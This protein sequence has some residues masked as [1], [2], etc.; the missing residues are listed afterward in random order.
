MAD[1]GNTPSKYDDVNVRA[2]V[3]AVIADPKIDHLGDAGDLRHLAGTGDHT[4]WSTHTGKYGYPTQGK[5]HAHD[6]SMSQADQNLFEAWVR[7]QWRNG[8]LKG[9]KY[10]NVNNRHWNIQTEANWQKAFKGTLKAT[11]STDHHCHVSYENGNYEYDLVKR[12]IAYRDRNKVA[13]GGGGSAPTTQEDDKVYAV[14]KVAGATNPAVY[15]GDYVTRRHVIDDTDLVKCLTLA[16]QTKPVEVS[17]EAL[18]DRYG[19]DTKVKTIN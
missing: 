4:L 9:L 5:I 2:N 8:S 18:L 19:V 7:A 15:V 11:S 16:K 3:L 12:F 6:F 17:S 1:I 13:S 14:V 10:F